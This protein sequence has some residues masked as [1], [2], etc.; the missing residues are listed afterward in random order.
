M[1]E[2]PFSNMT[3]WFLWTEEEFPS[4]DDAWVPL[5]VSHTP[6]Y[7]PAALPYLSLDVGW[8]LQIA[9]GSEDV[10]FDEGL[11]KPQG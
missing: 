6:E 11:L 3:G 10:W 4:G 9:P 1:H 5:H 7:V 8:R 2:Q